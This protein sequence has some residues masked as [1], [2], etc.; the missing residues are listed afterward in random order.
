LNRQAK[1]CRFFYALWDGTLAFGQASCRIPCGAGDG[2]NGKRG[3]A[4]D[5]SGNKQAAAK[6]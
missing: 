3:C 6:S 1:A 5:D 4:R 2:G